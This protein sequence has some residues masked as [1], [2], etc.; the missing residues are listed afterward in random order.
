MQIMITHGRLA[1]TRVLQ[2]APWQLAFLVLLLA[3]AM[4][5]L[6]GAIYHF[7]FLKAARDGWPVVSQLVK[8]V[9]KDE[10]A[11]RDRFMREN[12]DA[13]AQ[14]VGEMQA[15]LI[16]LEAVGERVSGLA[17]LKP[18]EIKPASD[19]QPAKPGEATGPGGQGGPFIPSGRPSL[20]ELNRAIDWLDEFS[21]QRADVFTMI[22]ARLFEEQMKSLMVPNTKPV[23]GHTSSGFGFRSDPFSGRSALHTGLDFPAPTGSPIMAAAGG[24]VVR[25]EAHPQYGNMIDLDHGNGLV[26]RYAHASRLL[27]QQG[28][29]VKRGQVI[30]HVGSTGRSTGPHL[31]FEVLMGGVHQDPAKFLTNDAPAATAVAERPSRG[32]NSR[33]ARS[34]AAVGIDATPAAP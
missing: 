9:V 5:A 28:D 25:A 32:R 15:K 6:S 7:I 11:Q 17:G 1:R 23:E 2:L 13:M 18:E 12:L 10:F 31:H 27:A 14:R 22:E 16:H 20:T 29:L 19:T 24:V 8:L 34:V 21:A 30:A 3:A 4:L 26:T 33:V